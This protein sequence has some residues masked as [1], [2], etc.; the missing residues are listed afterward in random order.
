MERGINGDAVSSRPA[1]RPL[2]KQLQ[3][4]QGGRKPLFFDAATRRS[5]NR[6][7]VAEVQSATASVGTGT[8]IGGI[9][10]TALSHGE[11][12]RTKTDPQ[13]ESAMRDNHLNDAETSSASILSR[14]G[15][16]I[17]RSS[18]LGLS[19]RR[20]ISIT[21]AFRI[22]NEE[23]EEAERER[24]SGGSPSPAPRS[25]RSRTRQDERSAEDRVN[26][27]SR[28]HQ[29]LGANASN[30][31]SSNK[32]KADEAG[33]GAAPFR[34]TGAA[35]S[36]QERIDEWRTSSRPNAASPTKRQSPIH[37]GESADEGRLP[38]LVPGIDDVVLHSIES[39]QPRMGDSSPAKDFTWHVEN[40]FT[41][42]EL[43]I[44]DSPRIKVGQDSHQ[45]FATRPSIVKDLK[46]RSPTRFG[47][48]YRRNQELDKIRARELLFGSDRNAVQTGRSS[49]PEEQS[50][51]QRHNSKLEEIRAS[52]AAVD[53]E[54]PVPERN[55]LRVKH[56]TKL[57]E[58]G[59]LEA[60]GLSKRA[61]AAARLVEIREK[62]A[63]TRSVSPNHNRRP[64]FRE[65]HREADVPARPK[66]AF[67][68]GGERVPD[69]PVTIFKDYGKRQESLVTLQAA[70]RRGADEAAAKSSGLDERDLLRRLARAA[71]ASPA[72]EP[73]AQRPISSEH[74]K[75]SESEKT[76]NK[77]ILAGGA[78]AG[79]RKSALSS[80]SGANSNE[81]NS[82]GKNGQGPKPTVGFSG[83]RRSNSSESDRSKRSSMLSESDPTARIEAEMNLF[84]PGDNYSERG[85][86]R[87]P[88]PEIDSDDQGPGN[89]GGPDGPDDLAEATPKPPQ[90]DFDALPTPRVTGAY[91]ETPVTVKVLE[92]I[93]DEEEENGESGV[94]PFKEKLKKQRE[95]EQ[96]DR[97][98]DAKD[99][100]TVASSTN[101]ALFRDKKAIL[102]WRSKNEDTASEPGASGDRSRDDLA[103]TSTATSG[104]PGQ[105]P[106]SRSLPRKRPPLKNTSK[107]PSVKDDLLELQRQHN[108]DDSTVDD[109]EDILAGRKQPSPQLKDLLERLPASA[110]DEKTDDQFQAIAEEVK[111]EALSD[112]EKDMSAGH[113]AI[114][115]K[116]SKTLTSGL[117]SIRDA[118]LGIQRLEDQVAHQ[119]QQKPA[120]GA[121]RPKAAMSPP[122]SVPI[123]LPQLHATTS[124]TRFTLLG[125]L[126]ALFSVWYASEW[127]MCAKYCRPTSCDASAPCIY[128][129]DDPV[130]GRALPVK[131]DQWTTGGHGRK[132]ASWIVEEVQDWVADVQDVLQGRSLQDVVPDQ[133][134]PEQR[135]QYVRR[136]R[137]HGMMKLPQRPGPEQQAK[138]D[139]WRRSRLAKERIREMRQMGYD[140]TDDD[141]GSLGADERVW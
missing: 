1:Q 100:N 34:R 41:A 52:E 47:S 131:L 96:K 134:T 51:R 139:S 50:V 59:K 58:I 113:M 84:A 95:R 122:P 40:D 135:R 106:R 109:L 94:K 128:S 107:L 55:Q 36:L 73:A 116:M 11:L 75:L 87:A 110:E 78:T 66:S 13:S 18:L 119:Q 132:A 82:K 60:Q 69:T 83:L 2:A 104:A 112:E 121:Q 14:G 67:E 37:T 72:S 140:V 26:H 74:Q 81:R 44:S 129:W 6:E 65:G 49:L 31:G 115:S 22:A 117:T 38:D 125:L 127:A 105:K 136:L 25:W 103:A 61:M 77:A 90:R 19:N 123:A 15:S 98:K 88:S 23:E 29:T 7:G 97:Q 42:G 99:Q 91:V 124:R 43:Q 57:A 70:V 46:I 118:K 80:V 33:T 102:A 10:T 45:P 141:G 53:K 48:P 17:P 54:M 93:K 76:V 28:A 24:S 92:N 20:P 86:V 12:R 4:N 16:R 71:S 120:T 130:F 27:L 30:S 32:P 9:K 5:A 111:Q 56:N 133:L 126:V 35:P 138:Y 101:N 79:G 8:R 39:P 108:M 3:I 137:K 68:A 114:V 89:G 63:M 85:S 62:N 21:E 64:A